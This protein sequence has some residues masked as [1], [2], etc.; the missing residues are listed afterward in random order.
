MAL[1][2]F[3]L[4][5]N[6]CQGINFEPHKMWGEAGGRTHVMLRQHFNFHEQRLGSGEQT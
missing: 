1:V 6:R 5:G 2:P 4:V 3:Q